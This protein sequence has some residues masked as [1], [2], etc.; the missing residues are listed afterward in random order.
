QIGRI[1]LAPALDELSTELV[2]L[3]VIHRKH[4]LNDAAAE[5][6]HRKREGLPVAAPG[7]RVIAGRLTPVLEADVVLV[8]P[9]V[10][11]LGVVRLAIRYGRRDA[12][13]VSLATSQCST[14]TCRPSIGWL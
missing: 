4:T 2:G 13:P 5:V 14:R 3:A 10:R 8:G 12:A 7:C 9:E 6:E 11:K 1:D